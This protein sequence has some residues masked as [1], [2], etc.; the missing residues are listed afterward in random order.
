[1][2]QPPPV[3]RTPPSSPTAHARAESSRPLNAVRMAVAGVMN[4]DPGIWKFGIAVSMNNGLAVDLAER[5][6]VKQMEQLVKDGAGR[7]GPVTDLQIY[8]TM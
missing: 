6:C 5:W 4:S 1:M 8:T 3:S 7:W 2:S